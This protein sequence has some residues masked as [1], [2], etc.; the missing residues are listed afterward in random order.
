MS[1]INN[2]MHQWFAY[3]FESRMDVNHCV[4]CFECGKTMQEET[5]KDLS[6]CYSHILGKKQYPM[7]K[8][9]PQNVK[10][11]HPDCHTLYTLKPKEAKNQYKEYLKLLKQYKNEFSN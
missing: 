2:P 9:N 11:V 3:L 6:T 7:Y 8:G 4:Q 10:I 5:Y 1:Y